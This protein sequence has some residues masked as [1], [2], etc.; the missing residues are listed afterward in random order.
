MQSLDVFM[1]RL[2]PL[3]PGCP[4]P[5]A[6]QALRDSA[7][8]FCEETHVVQV[9]TD[10]VSLVPDVQ[11]YDLDIPSQTE[12]SRVIKVWSGTRILT[13]VE[14]VLVDSPLLYNNPVGGE[15]AAT[16]NP[17]VVTV[18]QEGTVT[19]YPTPDTRAAANELLTARVAI[20]P[21]RAATQVHDTLYTSWAEAVVA[22]AAFRL[23][24]IPGAAFSD[25]ALVTESHSRFRYFINR[26]RIEANRGR[27]VG[28]AAV[29]MKPFA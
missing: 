17:R 18:S 20:R 28:P 29:R 15:Y 6:E 1:S 14:P 4:Y 19:L 23:A 27:L 21:T 7:I 2:L 11:I 13:Q 25:S 10:P 3:V 9:V 16:G 5:T 8:E 22:G 24:G 12:V 26:A